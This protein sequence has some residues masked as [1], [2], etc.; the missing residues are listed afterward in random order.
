[1]KPEVVIWVNRQLIMEYSP[2]EFIGVK[3]HH[4]NLVNYPQLQALSGK[5]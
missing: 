5:W 4:L 2:D 1:M 3:D